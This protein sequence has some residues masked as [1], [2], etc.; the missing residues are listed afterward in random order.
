MLHWHVFTKFND[1]MKKHLMINITNQMYYILSNKN[2]RRLLELLK[3]SLCFCP[4]PLHIL[5]H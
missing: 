4:V 2:I 5:H 1:R 3:E